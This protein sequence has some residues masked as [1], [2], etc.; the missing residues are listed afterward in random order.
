M[1]KVTKEVLKEIVK[2]C[3]VEILAEGISGGNVASLNESI[4]NHVLQRK[5]QK[6]TQ[7]RLMKNILPPKEKVKN[8]GFEK[9]LSK[10][11]SNATQDPV[12]ASLLADTAKTTLQE[13]NSADSSNRFAARPSDNVSQIVANTDPNEL[14][15]ESASN[16][17]QLAF[18]DANK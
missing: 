3:L 17:A 6:T 8:E 4:E 14:F 1:A 5:P 11:I 9:K 10:T 2:E 7:S 18:S 15:S 12:M 13:Q 16:W